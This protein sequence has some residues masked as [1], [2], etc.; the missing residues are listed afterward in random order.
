[1][2]FSRLEFLAVGP[3]VYE[4]FLNEAGGHR[5][6]R[7]PPTEKRGRRQTSTVTVAVLPMVSE[8]EQS[9]DP[10]DLEWETKKGGGNGGQNM[11][12]NETS[13]RIRHIPTGITVVCQDERSQHRN[14]ERALEVLRARL[15]AK[16]LQ[17]SSSEENAI[18]KAQVGSGQRGDKIRTYRFQDDRVVDHRSGKKARLSDILAGD[19]DL[20]R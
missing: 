16:I 20:L 10:A 11:Q 5:V 3:Q 18:R 6:Q 8:I 7:I 12:K 1:M 17:D 9:I 2:G 19:L 4:L 13:V 14:K 15:Y